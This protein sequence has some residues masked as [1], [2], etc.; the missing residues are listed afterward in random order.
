MFARL[1]FALATEIEPEI[2]LVDEIVG[3]GDEFFQRKSIHR[4]QNMMK[5]GM[6]TL[7]VS[8]HL[9][10]LVAQCDRLIWIDQ[11][12]IVMDDIPEKVAD[13]YRYEQGQFL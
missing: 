2:L 3:V 4:M 13:T 12:K 7:I 5:K 11:G 8:H 6:T 10:F 1:A 9:D